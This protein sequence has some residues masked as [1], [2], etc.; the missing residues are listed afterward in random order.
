MQEQQCG[1]P[2]TIEVTGQ[3]AFLSRAPGGGNVFT[4]FTED[5]G[6]SGTFT[7]QIAGSIQVPNGPEEGASQGDR[8]ECVR[9]A[10]ET[11]QSIAKDPGQSAAARVSAARALLTYAPRA[12]AK[13]RH[14][15]GG[16]G[17]AAPN[18]REVVRP[19]PAEVRARL[20]IA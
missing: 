16:G 18:P 4:I 19:T 3:P 5:F 8:E 14:A 9:V 17:E 11:L 2:E 6:L 10:L 13:V 15:S 12:R 20:G 1:Y 7:M